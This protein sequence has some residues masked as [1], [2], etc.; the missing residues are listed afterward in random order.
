MN[1]SAGAR[2]IAIGCAYGALAVG[3]GAFGAHA[4]RERLEQAGHLDTWQTAVLYHALHALALV[5]YGL[6]RAH[7]RAA[8]AQDGACRAGRPWAGIAFALGLLAFSGSLYGLALGGPR[9]LGP[10]TPS[11]GALLLLGWILFA[12][13]ALRLARRA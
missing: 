6:W 9:V 7:A 8:C 13:E 2:W 11:G 12:L 4:L 10:V 3:L 5:G 1:A